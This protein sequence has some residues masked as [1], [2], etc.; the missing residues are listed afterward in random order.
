[1]S[2]ED[3]ITTEC[4]ELCEGNHRHFSGNA[5]INCP[6]HNPKEY[7]YE[8]DGSHVH[9]WDQVDNEDS[10]IEKND[11]PACG[12]PLEK[13]TQ[14]C[15][16]DTLKPKECKHEWEETSN[17][18]ISKFYYCQKCESVAW[19]LPVKTINE[20]DF[21]TW[22]DNLVKITPFN[23]KDEKQAEILELYWSRILK[24]K[25]GKAFKEY[26]SHQ[27]DRMLEEITKGV[28]ELKG[29]RPGEF[30][31]GYNCAIDNINY[32]LESSYKQK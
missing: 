20:E 14:C 32:L 8:R 16:C 28:E 17:E 18:K 13:H 11:T 25:I 12:Q 26:L 27:K 1:M 23:E 22:L 6:C 2:K 9:C 10:D 30:G 3:K 5:R 4:C 7:N 29:N 15:L 31:D 19:S 24:E 21:D